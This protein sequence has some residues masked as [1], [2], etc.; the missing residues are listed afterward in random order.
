MKEEA[1]K[2]R[3]AYWNTHPEGKRK[4]DEERDGLYREIEK[5]RKEID[6]IPGKEDVQNLQEKLDNLWQKKDY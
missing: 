4:L 5:K 1:K 3:E 2:R 6:M